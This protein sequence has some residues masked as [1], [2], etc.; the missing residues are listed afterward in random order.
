MSTKRIIALDIGQKRIGLARSDPGKTL[1]F[2]VDT[3]HL[4]QMLKWV[5]DH[6]LEIEH[7]V[8][9]W[10]LDLQ[11]QTNEGT[12]RVESVQTALRR[13]FPDI[14]QSRIDERFTSKMASQSILDS[15]ISKK[16]RRD[17]ALIDATAAAI[18]LQDYLDRKA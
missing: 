16:K 2:K 1:A 11:G 10:P 7:I 12:Q 13:R 3:F 6:K 4:E 14:P 15:G 9:G 18:I 8:L 17:K 5:Q